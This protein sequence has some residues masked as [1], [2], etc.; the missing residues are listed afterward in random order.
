[1]KIK[2]N[3]Q[4]LNLSNTARNAGVSRYIFEL[5]R[6]LDK[7]KDE[8]I[9]I[10]LNYKNYRP[11]FNNIKCLLT[12]LN[13]DNPLIRILWE[14]L[15]LLFK[16]KRKDI[17]HFP[18]PSI[19]S[20]F[21]RSPCIIT[22]HDLAFIKFKTDSWL[23]NRY[24]HY[25]LKYSLKKAKKIIAVSES[26]KKD[27]IHYF[28]I[29]PSKIRVL[30]E[31]ANDRFKVLKG[32]KTNLGKKLLLPKK[33]ILSL[34]TIEPRKNLSRLIEA[35]DKLN[36]RE[37]KLIIAGAKGWKY[38]KIFEKLDSLKRRRDI[39]FTGY[40]DDKD[41]PQLYNNA[42]VFVFP[43]LYEGFGLPVLEAMS[44]GCPVI[45]SNTSSLPE[46]TCK[47]SILINPYDIKEITRAI[48]KVLT[49]NK[50]RSK[51]IKEGLKQSKKFSWKKCAKET[52]E[53]YKEVFNE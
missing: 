44:C 9:S 26:T 49:D 34:G 53:V 47:A 52:L 5:L 41:L 17:I 11:F 20:P 19:I 38:K 39:I 21:I 1:M 50:L 25:S 42:S 40:I 6:E 23:K 31:A 4:M 28:G 16:C 36:L 13:T 18:V 7:Y 2:I 37:Y 12:R 29:K 45:T 51:L 35:F 43:S 3:A 8:N 14:Q 33:Y 46:V 27:I 24:R 10:F 48:K 30:Y 15:I 32:S 22:V